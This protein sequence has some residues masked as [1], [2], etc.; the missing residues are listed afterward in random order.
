MAL[1]SYREANHVQWQ[2]SRPAHDGTQVWAYAS[3]INADWP[4]YT[5]GVGETLFLCECF[6][7]SVGNITGTCSLALFTGLW[8]FQRYLCMCDTIA[9]VQI[10]KDH[11]TFW[12]PLEVP[13]GYIIGVNSNALGLTA[14]G[15][16]FGWR[17]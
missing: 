11:C 14:H 16:I 13:A 5:V 4:V 17:E 1:M 6:L 10:Q 3:I 15:Q 2:G 12:P 9:D 8:A 7:N